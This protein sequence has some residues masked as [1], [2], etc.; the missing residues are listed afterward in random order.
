MRVAAPV[1]WLNAEQPNLARLGGVYT[2]L[3][4]ADGSKENSTLA[5]DE[6]IRHNSSGHGWKFYAVPAMALHVSY[7]PEHRRQRLKSR[8]QTCTSRRLQHTSSLL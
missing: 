8:Y 4:L 3:V 7:L 2:D 1:F 5:Y 6:A